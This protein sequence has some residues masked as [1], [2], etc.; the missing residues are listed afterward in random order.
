MTNL[1]PRQQMELANEDLESKHRQRL[2]KQVRDEMKRQG[3]EIADLVF[4]NPKLQ[5]RQ[6]RNFV[7]CEKNIHTSTLI[8]ISIALGGEIN[9]VP[10]KTRRRK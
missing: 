9:F 1:D 8:Q 7:D 2:V 5:N 3:R 4:T 6:T 10:R